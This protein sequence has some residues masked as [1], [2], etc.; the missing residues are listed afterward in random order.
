MDLGK[1][2]VKENMA[3]KTKEPQYQECWDDFEQ[4]GPIELGPMTSHMWRTDPRHFGFCLARYK[5]VAKMLHGKKS[6]LEIGCGD[7]FSAGVVSQEVELVDGLDFDPLCVEASNKL[8]EKNENMNFFV[9]DMKKTDQEV[10]RQ[11][12]AVYSMDVLEHIEEELED[13][14]ME[15]L[16]SFLVPGGVAIIGC[17]SLE[18]QTHAS[19]WSREGHVNCKTGYDLKALAEK[20]FKH[21]FL[22][23]MND[24][25]LHTGY[26]KMAHYNLVLACEQR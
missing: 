24:E 19:Y 11:Y 21:A 25:V 3:D 13:R 7:G 18:S 12:E 23:G 14:Y 6:A 9:F 16:L 10:K 1:A 22:F 20:Y 8:W 17:P 26:S 5:F 4:N 2:I 15:N